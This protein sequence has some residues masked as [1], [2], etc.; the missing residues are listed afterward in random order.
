MARLNKQKDLSHQEVSMILDSI[1][2]GV[3][4]V[5][6][7]FVIT[8]F[9]KAAETI[10]GV[11]VEE[12]LGRPCYEVFRAEICEADCA[13]KHTVLTGKPVVTVSRSTDL[14]SMGRGS[15]SSWDSIS[16]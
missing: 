5:D 6:E 11:P 16:S 15:I 4:T 10:T 2:D 1:A 7:N 8:S 12:A 14:D 13:L 9:N 3:F